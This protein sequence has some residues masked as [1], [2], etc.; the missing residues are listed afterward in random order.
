MIY[1]PRR[2][3]GLSTAAE[4]QTPDSRNTLVVLFAAV[5]ARY[6]QPLAGR[7]LLRCLPAPRLSAASAGRL[8]PKYREEE[9]RFDRGLQQHQPPPSSLALV[10]GVLPALKRW[11]RPL[12][13]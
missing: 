9:Q 7:R 4:S 5:A 3:V 11:C 12:F 2:A 13:F 8:K 6:G 10:S 1:A